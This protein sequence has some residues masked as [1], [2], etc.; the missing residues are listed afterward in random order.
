MTT[1]I[2]AVAGDDWVV[3]R[4]V[5]HPYLRFTDEHGRT[6]RGRTKVIALLRMT[7][8]LEP[9]TEIALRDG[10]VYSWCCPDI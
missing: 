4:R 8:T 3:L 10:Q 2:G 7:E 6:T 5:L 1:V 9:P